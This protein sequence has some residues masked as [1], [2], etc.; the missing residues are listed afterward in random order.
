[1]VKKRTMD[2]MIGR[3]ALH[4]VSVAMLLE[5]TVK[6]HVFS[7]LSSLTPGDTLKTMILFQFGES[8][9]IPESAVCIQKKV[10]IFWKEKAPSLPLMVWFQRSTYCTMF[11]WV[12]WIR[13]AVIP[14]TGAAI[15]TESWWTRPASEG[16][17]EWL[18]LHSRKARVWFAVVWLVLCKIFDT[19]NSSKTT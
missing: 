19:S 11:T 9:T 16:I 5:H 17:I 6:C 14:L 18:T 13:V 8:K 3:I 15:A 7:R 1:M 12:A 10:N 4:P 2:L